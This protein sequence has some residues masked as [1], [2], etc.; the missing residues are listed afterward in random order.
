MHP[1]MHIVYSTE[2]GKGGSVI[3]SVLMLIFMN[4]MGPIDSTN[5]MLLVGGLDDQS[6]GKTLH[7]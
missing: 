3:R 2:C 4:I 7:F 6:Q 5:D 1:Y